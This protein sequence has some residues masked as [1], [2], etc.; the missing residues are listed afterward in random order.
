MNQITLLKGHFLWLCHFIPSS[1]LVKWLSGLNSSFV[2]LWFSHFAHRVGVP[3]Y[4]W[5]IAKSSRLKL[6]VKQCFSFH[7]NLCISEVAFEKYPFFFFL[8]WGPLTPR[9][10]SV[11]GIQTYLQC[12]SKSLAPPVQ[13]L[14]PQSCN[15]SMDSSLGS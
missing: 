10:A 6:P 14:L 15:K 13:T 12:L 2:H 1:H 11:L 3:N 8:S 9:K 7:S 4:L 5:I